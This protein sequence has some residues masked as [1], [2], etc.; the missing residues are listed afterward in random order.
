MILRRI[1]AHVKDQNWFAV[2][3]DF[4]IVVIGVFSASNR[5]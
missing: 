4:V 5:D 3:V 2:G 1:S